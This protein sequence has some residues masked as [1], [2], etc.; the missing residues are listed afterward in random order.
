MNLFP[1]R[2]LFVAAAFGVALTLGGCQQAPSEDAAAADTSATSSNSLEE[3]NEKLTREFIEE[4]FNKRNLAHADKT[5]DANFV[6]HNPSPGQKQGLAGFKES[7]GPWID[8]MP[9]M[10]M[11]V[12]DVVTKGDLVFAHV[13]QTGTFASDIAGMQTKGKKLDVRGVDIIRIKDGKATEHWGYYEEAK[14]MQQLGM[15]PPMDGSAPADTA[16]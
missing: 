13:H 7:M 5:L 10:K 8:A 3:T 9:D 2:S 11:E 16:K 14:M 1:V 6:E 12:L 15:M 4:V